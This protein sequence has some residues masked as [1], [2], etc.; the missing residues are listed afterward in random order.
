MNNRI[1]SIS[2]FEMKSFYNFFSQI[3]AQKVLNQVCLRAI[4]CVL[5]LLVM[6]CLEKIYKNLQYLNKNRS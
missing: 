1:E 6:E 2:S 4:F 5:F 3:K